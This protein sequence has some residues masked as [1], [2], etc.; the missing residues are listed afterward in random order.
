MLLKVHIVSLTVIS[1]SVHFQWISQ[2]KINLL[3]TSF[4]YIYLVKVMKNSY[5]WIGIRNPVILSEKKMV[6][7]IYFLFYTLPSFKLYSNV[8]A[9]DN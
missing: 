9:V 8:L 7:Y 6:S 3:K 5:I 1:L 2:S 4:R